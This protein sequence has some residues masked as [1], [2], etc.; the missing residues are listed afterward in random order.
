M[1]ILYF[2]PREVACLDQRMSVP[3]CIAEALTDYDP[4]HDPPPPFKTDEVEERAD[5]MW[6]ELKTTG[7]ITIE[8]DLDRAILEDAIDGSVFGDFIRDDVT[9]GN[10]PK[11]EADRWR[12]AMKTIETKV[13]IVGINATFP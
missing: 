4:D 11:I 8:T 3:E 6:H 12:R 1:P 9:D 10:M 2:T 13:K 7:T 5:A